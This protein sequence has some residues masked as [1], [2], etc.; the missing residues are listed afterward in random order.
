MGKVPYEILQR[1]KRKNIPVWLV[2]GRVA[3]T[4]KL[5]H[6]GFASVTCINSPEIVESSETVGGNPMDPDVASRRLASLAWH[7]LRK[8][9]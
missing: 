2:A 4:D 5:L 6:A 9:R 8:V 3:D 1:G 7:H